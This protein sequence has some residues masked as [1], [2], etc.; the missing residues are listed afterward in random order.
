LVNFYAWRDETSSAGFK[1]PTWYAHLVREC[2]S[3]K[4]KKRPSA[5]EIVDYL[6]PLANNSWSPSFK[7][8][9][10]RRRLY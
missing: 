4:A 5:K 8:N 7:S 6:T 1:C 10:K 2:T 3:E 9:T